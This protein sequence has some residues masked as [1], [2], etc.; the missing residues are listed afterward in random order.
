MRPTPAPRARA[1]SASDLLLPCS[2]SRPPGTPAAQGDVQLAAGGDVEP[3]PLLVGEP[4]H[5]QAQKGLGGVGDAVAPGGHGLPAARAGGGPRRR[6]TAGCRT[7]GEL[8]QVHAADR[9]RPSAPDASWAAGSPQRTLVGLGAGHRRPT[10]GI[11]S[12]VEGR[13]A[14]T[15]HPQSARP[16]HVHGSDA[17]VQ[18]LLPAAPVPPTSAGRCAPGATSSRVRALREVEADGEADAR[19][20]DEP[21]PGLGERRADVSASTGQSW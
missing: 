9:S 12:A 16:G 5:R 10:P 8:E 7:L 17:T 20:L 11:C 3:H 21:Q 2:T 13:V 4:G 14:R 19:R 15:G 18:V 6:R 1:S